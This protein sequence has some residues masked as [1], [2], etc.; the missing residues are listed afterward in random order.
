M[1]E[2]IVRVLK[3]LNDAS[4]RENT[5][6]VKV[7]PAERMS[8]ITDDTGKFF[9]VMLRAMGAKHVLEVGMS[10]GF[11]TIWMA[12]AVMSA[13]GRVVSIEADPKKISRAST[14]FA[15]A[16]VMDCVDIK[17]GMAIDILASMGESR[18]YD[19]FFDFAL[20]DA[21]KENVLAYFDAVLG[22]V[23]TGGVIATDNM[24]HP[25]KFSSAMGRFADAVRQKPAVRSVLI[26]V[27]NGEELS[28]KL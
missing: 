24:I 18:K 21:D 7:A 20:I 27:G 26:P 16:G 3:D 14:N 12:E 15:R 22:M 9:N 6:S 2:D 28:V 19:S 13:G 17:R 25:R 1:N 11:S 5:G 8:A 10:V 23:R 4:E